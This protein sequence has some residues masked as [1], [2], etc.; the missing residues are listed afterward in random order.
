MG[1]GTRLPLLRGWTSLG[2]AFARRPKAPVHFAISNRK[3]E[4]RHSWPMA[5]RKAKAL[6]RLDDLD[7]K[8]KYLLYSC[9]CIP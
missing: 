4:R 2:R 1:A 6:K 9:G 7:V 3:L 5:A 8:V